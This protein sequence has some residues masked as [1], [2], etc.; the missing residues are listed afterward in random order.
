MPSLRE[1]GTWRIESECARCAACCVAVRPDML[2]EAGTRCEFLG[3]GC[4]PECVIREGIEA[5][6]TVPVSSEALA[7]WQSECKD[8][9][10]LAQDGEPLTDAGCRSLAEHL[11]DIGCGFRV[12]RDG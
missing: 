2:D 6:Y 8:F 5:A 7:Y 12:V 10:Q 11:R 1:V 3:D 9:P 4:P